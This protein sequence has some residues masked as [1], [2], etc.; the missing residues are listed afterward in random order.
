MCLIAFALHA[1]PR[2]ALLLAANR[3]EFHERPAQAAQWWDDHPGIYGGRDLSAGGTWL[4]LHRRGRL[5]A[6]TNFREGR[7]GQP[8]ERSRGDLSRSFLGSAESP[9]SFAKG[10]IPDLSRYA[11]FNLLMFDWSSR[12]LSCHYLSN[13]FSEPLQEVGVGL[14]GLSNHLLGTPWPKVERLR[15]ALSNALDSSDDP[16]PLLLEALADQR[17]VAADELTAVPTSGDTHPLTRTPFIADARYGTRASTLVS[18]THD[19]VLRFLERSWTWQGGT[20]A[21]TGERSLVLRP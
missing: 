20:A 15:A 7:A 4:G 21:V 12:D 3:D 14:H 17:P 1:S 18:I 8:G 10:L 16:F 13:R 11:G 2:Y 19:G 5:A 6:I 9:G